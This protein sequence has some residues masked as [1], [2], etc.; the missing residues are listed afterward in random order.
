M[1]NKTSALFGLGIFLISTSA[2]AQSN[3]YITQSQINQPNGVAGLDGVG[4][5]TAPLNTSGSIKAY[6]S[7]QLGTLSS[8]QPA[9]MQGVPSIIDGALAPTSILLGGVGNNDFAPTKITS[10]LIG[11]SDFGGCVL[12]VNDSPFEQFSR[13]GTGYDESIGIM[14]KVSN[15]AP[16]LTLGVDASNVS[17]PSGTRYTVTFSGDGFTVRPALSSKDRALL[18]AH[19]RVYSNYYNGMVS[20]QASGSSDNPSLWYSYLWDWVDASDANGN[21]TIIHV[22]TSPYTNNKG[23]VR[24]TPDFSS[25]N[26]EIAPGQNSG[27]KFDYIVSNYSHPAVFIGQ[28]GKKFVVNSMIQLDA[29]VPNSPTRAAEGEELD[30]QLLDKDWWAHEKQFTVHGKTIVLTGMDHAADDSYLERLAGTNLLKKGLLIDGMMYGGEPLSMRDGGFHFYSQG[31]LA[32][33]PVGKSQVSQ[34][35]T[36]MNFSGNFSTLLLYGSH[37]RKA[38]DG[39]STGWGEEGSLHMGLQEKANSDALDGQDVGCINCTTG[40]QIVWNPLGHHYG[41]GV[42]TGIGTNI[43]YGLI[44]DLDG[45]TTAPQG[46]TSAGTLSVSSDVIATGQIKSS[47]SVSAVSYSEVLTTPASSTAACKAGQFTDDA[48]NHY[49]CVADNHWRRVALQDF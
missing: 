5:L 32:A 40:G 25:V 15:R 39:A 33:V 34:Q 13:C 45:K 36:S 46:L 6:G 29:T 28:V 19:S 20:T 22:S 23:W 7:T 11:P 8:G 43:K 31:D 12:S 21:Y 4:N 38:T 47:Q 26:T 44:V 42:G 14:E 18:V 16:R 41:I 30:L 24:N 3:E 49:V 37:D 9:I 2:L 17:T 10:P 27:D 48:N 35:L 1:K